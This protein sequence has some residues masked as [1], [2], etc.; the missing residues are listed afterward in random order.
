MPFLGING[1][2][3]FCFRGLRCLFVVFSWFKVFFLLC[4]RG[5][6]GLCMF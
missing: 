1:G 4:F 2:F 5:I 3:L 6:G